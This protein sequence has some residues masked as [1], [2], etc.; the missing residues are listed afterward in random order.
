MGERPAQS[1]LSA[2]AGGIRPK[3][4]GDAQA[5]RALG[6]RGRRL[7]AGEVDVVVGGT[8]RDGVVAGTR[9]SHDVA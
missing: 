2:H 6:V 7:E 4:G 1:R 9:V 3:H 8:E 5:W